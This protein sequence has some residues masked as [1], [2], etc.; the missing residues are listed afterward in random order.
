MRF[1]GDVLGMVRCLG[2][3]TFCVKWSTVVPLMRQRRKSPLYRLISERR[4]FFGFI[5]LSA[6]VAMVM[7]AK[8]LSVV[9]LVCS[10][11][12]RHVDA[13]TSLQYYQFSDSSNSISVLGDA[14]IYIDDLALELT[15]KG[16]GRA[17]YDYPVRTVSTSP[18]TSISFETTFIFSIEKELSTPQSYGAGLTFSMSS[19]NRTVGD[20]GAYLGLATATPSSDIAVATTKYF[21]LEFDTRQDTQFQ[22]MNDN[23]VGVDFSSLVSDQAKPAMSG[24]TPVVLASGNHI[25]AYVTYNSLAHV[26]DVSISPYTNG[27]YVKPAESLLSVPI[28]LSTVLNEFMYVGFSAATGAGTVR[29]K[30]WSWTF[31]TT[32]VDSTGQPIASPPDADAYL[33]PGPAPDV[34]NQGFGTSAAGTNLCALAILALKLAAVLSVVLISVC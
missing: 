12:S 9:C 17:T 26:L 8:W 20:P 25:Q 15:N 32:T 33:A 34:T 7:P 6:E 30:V 21:A 13:D 29:H 2:H 18:Q 1:V 16:A 27:D 10:L 5:L 4:S 28:D 31:K 14:R 23:H 19:E 11:I 22:D 3:K 24:A